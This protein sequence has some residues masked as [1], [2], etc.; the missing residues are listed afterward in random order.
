MSKEIGF[1]RTTV[2]PR[3]VSL[4]RGDSG[5][6]SIAATPA[7]PSIMNMNGRKSSR[8]DAPPLGSICE[9]QIGSAPEVKHNMLKC[10]RVYII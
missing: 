8:V 10:H 6:S 2:P 9:N 5:Y 4:R 7:T 1:E 3:K